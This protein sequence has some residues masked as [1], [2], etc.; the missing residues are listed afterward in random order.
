MDMLFVDGGIN[1]WV[2]ETVELAY[3]FQLVL[4]LS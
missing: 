4:R 3:I 1:I 2:E